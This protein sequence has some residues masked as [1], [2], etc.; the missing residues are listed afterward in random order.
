LAA[1]MDLK[2]ELQKAIAKSTMK[3]EQKTKP[4]TPYDTGRLR[5]SIRSYLAPNIGKIF[6][7][8]DYAIF[9]HEGTS[10]WP[11]SKPPKAAGTVRQFLKVGLEKS[12]RDI[13]TYFEQAIEN[14]WNKVI[15]K[16]NIYKRL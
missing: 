10:K 14:T 7:T 3:V 5:A 4:I 2:K 9:V 8:V 16:T 15:A 11:L 6:P 1:P 12:E 13:Q